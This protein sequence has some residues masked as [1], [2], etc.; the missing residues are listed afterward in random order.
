MAK[1]DGRVAL[2]TGTS[3]GIGAAIAR[4]LVEDGLT[5]AGV[6][7]SGSPALRGSRFHDVVLDLTDAQ[8]S[9]GL[10]QRVVAATG[11][12][13]LLVNNAGLHATAPCWELPSAQFES[14]VRTNLTG[15]FLLCQQVL[16]H[17]VETETVGTIINLC[18]IESEVGWAEPPQAGYAVTKGGMVGLTRALAYDFGWR[19]IRVNGLAPG[20]VNTEISPPDHGML[21]QRIP[22]QG[23][24]AT[25]D[26]IAA[27]ASFLA[28][29]DASYITGEILYVDGG[30]RLP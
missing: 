30:Y 24:L 16:R 6:S 2:V 13:D 23:R 3:R 21:A 8:E 26:E 14:L 4:R 20:V 17:W 29:D 10:V 28:S 7:R 19:G 25:V 1:P 15:P 11:R 5:V 12:M 22:L 18:S 27:A 9:S